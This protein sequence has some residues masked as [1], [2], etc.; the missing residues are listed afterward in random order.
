[1]VVE[2]SLATPV[3]SRGRGFDVDVCVGS[4]RTRP[5]PLAGGTLR[6]HHRLSPGRPATAPRLSA[7]SAPS[8]TPCRQRRL[9]RSPHAPS[10]TSHP[11]AFRLVGHLSSVHYGITYGPSPG[12]ACIVVERSPSAGRQLEPAT[13]GFGDRALPAELRPRGWQHWHLRPW[14][15]HSRRGSTRALRSVIANRKGRHDT[16]LVELYGADVGK[17]LEVRSGRSGQLLL[18]VLDDLAR[19]PCPIL[20][21]ANPSL[22]LAHQRVGPP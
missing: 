7:F 14:P 12:R 5:R 22:L 2:S 13:C 9:R 21:L 16:P 20:S 3:V 19:I 6:P 11:R 8:A 17:N 1:M 18:A 4:C 15:T 10:F